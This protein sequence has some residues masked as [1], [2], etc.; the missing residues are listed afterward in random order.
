MNR[1]V[2]ILLY[3]IG[4]LAILIG[5]PTFGYGLFVPAFAAE[6]YL[7]MGALFF[8]GG[9]VL[10]WLAARTRRKKGGDIKDVQNAIW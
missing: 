2:R 6:S 3:L 9:I 8:I 7:F 4:A 5:L 10:I 1:A